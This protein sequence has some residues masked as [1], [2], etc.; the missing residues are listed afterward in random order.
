MITSFKL[1]L[2]TNALKKNPGVGVPGPG[3]SAPSALGGLRYGFVNEYHRHPTDSKEVIWLE[4]EKERIREE[5][6]M[7]EIVRRR[8][9]IESEVRRE[10]MLGRQMALQDR[11]GEF[12]FSAPQSSVRIDPMQFPD[13]ILHHKV[14][15]SSHREKIGQ[16]LEEGIVM[17]SALKPG[18][19]SLGRAP[20]RS[21]EPIIS[22]VNPESET[23]KDE[24]R[25]TL[26]EKAEA[27]VSGTKR[28][29]VIRPTI[30][31]SESLSA[32][33]TPNKKMKQ[34]WRCTLCKVSA[35][36][37]QSL[38]DHL[39]GKKHIGKEAGLMKT[40]TNFSIGWSPSPIKKLDEHD[41]IPA[42]CEIAGSR[43]PLETMADSED[44]MGSGTPFPSH[45]NQLASEETSKGPVN[46]Q[47]DEQN[48]FMFWCEMCQ[49]GAY[50]M[51]VME[52]HRTGKKHLVRLL[53]C[54]QNAGGGNGEPSK[55]QLANATSV[56][57][58]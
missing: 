27:N 35:T 5:I 7:E 34:D 36:S 19:S 48:P 12:F 41:T 54:S 38:N 52:A 2:N 24:D 42:A 51:D 13:P 11:G 25:I 21:R 20:G 47:D 30:E 15:G 55:F 3:Y 39:R 14:E 4:I 6:I 9:M 16:S 53:K 44:T 28:K 40:G 22:E 56:S 8:N 50:T 58:I 26:K 29:T 23:S 10:L 37:E 17:S 1:G 57:E 45:V 33:G 18:F 46:A 49:V 32:V 43:S 31:S